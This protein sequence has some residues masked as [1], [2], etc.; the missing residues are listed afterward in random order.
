M[1]RIEVS[2]TAD[3]DDGF[4]KSDE[5]AFGYIQGTVDTE[6]TQ[7]PRIDTDSHGFWGF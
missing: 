7:E 1:D 4:S 6:E 2:C 5:L 3:S